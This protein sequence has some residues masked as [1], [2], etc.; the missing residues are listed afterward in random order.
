MDI[1]PLIPKGKPVLQR[2]GEGGFMVSGEWLEG[3]VLILP[4]RAERLGAWTLG[5]SVEGIT[6]LLIPSGVE[7]LLVGCGERMKII[8]EAW[9]RELRAKGITIDAM[10]TGAASRTYSVLLAEGRAVA[11]LLVAV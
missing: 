5:D 8:P 4:D 7:M 3:T 6:A 10:D 2:Y 1:T 11:A 9:R